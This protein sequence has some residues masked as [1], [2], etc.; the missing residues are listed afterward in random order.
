MQVYSYNKSQVSF[1]GAV[2]IPLKELEGK[3]IQVSEFLNSHMG[4]DGACMK[5]KGGLS[6][7]ANIYITPHGVDCKKESLL[8]NLLNELR[9]DY[10]HCKKNNMTPEEFE[11]F[12]KLDL[13]I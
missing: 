2:R 5:A 9:M 11:K 8:L 12:C 13:T 7:D 6:T 10:H 3:T 4:I 1:Q